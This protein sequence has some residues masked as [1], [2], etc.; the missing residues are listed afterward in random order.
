MTCWLTVV[1][2]FS[3]PFSNDTPLPAWCLTSKFKLPKCLE[4]WVI[5]VK[6][7]SKAAHT[8]SILSYPSGY[9]SIHA[10]RLDDIP[11]AGPSSSR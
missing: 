3:N 9:P 1:C 10:S 4:V 6:F 7:Y 8:S 5:L 11:V 2:P